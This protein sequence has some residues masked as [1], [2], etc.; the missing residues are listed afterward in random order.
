MKKIF[1]IF[2]NEVRLVALSC[3][4]A[5][6]CDFLE[7][8]KIGKSDIESFYDSPESVKA[9]VTG[10]YSLM[11]NL[12][13][14]YMVLY[15]EIC[16]DMVTMDASESSAWS[17]LYNFDLSESYN[18]TPIGF[19]WKSAYE[20][21]LNACEVI[22]YAPQVSARYPLRTQEVDSQIAQAHYLRALATLDLALCY[23]QHYGY[24][25][26]ASHLGVVVMRSFPN[27]NA[28]IVRSSARET[29]GFILEDLATAYSL[30]PDDSSPDTHYVSKA[31]VEALRARVYLYMEDYEQALAAAS[32]VIGNYGFSLTPREGYFDMF[33]TVNNRGSETIFSLDGY[34]E[35]RDL[36]KA[37]DYQTHYLLPSQKLLDIFLADEDAA[38]PDVRYSLLNYDGKTGSMGCSMKYTILEEVS[39]KEKAVDICVS[40]LSE[41]HLIRAEALCALGRDLDIA[42]SDIALLR[43]RATGLPE[44]SCMPEYS[45]AEELEKAVERERL[46]ELFHEGFRLWDIS[47]H[48]QNLERDASSTATVK[49]ME[50][51]NDDFIFPIPGV[52]IE[53][54]K[55]IQPNP[56]NETQR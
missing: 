34:S 42:A 36:T 39:D 22:D 13:D 5:V 56:N 4:C 52:E 18:A 9:A 29:Y 14:K 17:Y 2:T 31:A 37:F 51:P 15:P 23:S 28:S 44:S 3:L 47:R 10:C 12:T 19:V 16:G 11:N 49:F 8:E 21:V 46:K 41:M 32:E 30:L 26:D 35:S 33:T 40:R 1:D 7:V 38:H 54:N 27:L 25:A 20:I 45:D 43:S 48:R 50:Y 24:S 6:S 55:E 53:A